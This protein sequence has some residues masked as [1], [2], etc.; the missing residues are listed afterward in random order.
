MLPDRA[1]ASPSSQTRARPAPDE[2]A[3]GPAPERAPEQAQ[4]RVLH[5]DLARFNEHGHGWVHG[6]TAAG[7]VPGQHVMVT[8]EEADTVRAVVLHVQDDRAQVQVLWD[9]VVEREEGA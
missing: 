6:R 7:L 3:A 9:Q 8:D 4:P 5:V 2:R 1:G